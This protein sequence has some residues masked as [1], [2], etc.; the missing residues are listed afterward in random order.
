MTHVPSRQLSPAFTLIEL[1]VVISIIALLIAILLPALGRA[2]DAARRSQCLGHTRQAVLG[3]EM[4]SS[5]NPNFF[6]ACYDVNTTW[7]TNLFRGGYI[8][9]FI[10][11]KNHADPNIDA[12]GDPAVTDKR[13]YGGVLACPSLETLPYS[14]VDTIKG[15]TAYYGTAYGL[16]WIPWAPASV[17]ITGRERPLAREWVLRPSTTFLTGDGKDTSLLEYRNIGAAATRGPD[18]RHLDT[19]SMS[20]W[21]GHATSLTVDLVPRGSSNAAATIEWR[22]R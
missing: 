3:F 16:N 15:V 4:Y 10:V 17:G 7:H 5:D 8:D 11:Q 21:D 12:V 6:P 2:R 14:R 19:V 20:Y 13:P 18:Y 9:P 1:L 22:G